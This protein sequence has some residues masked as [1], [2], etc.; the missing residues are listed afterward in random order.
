MKEPSAQIFSSY[1]QGLPEHL[2]NHVQDA[3]LGIKCEKKRYSLA[4]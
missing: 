1:I 2:E 3:I 4:S